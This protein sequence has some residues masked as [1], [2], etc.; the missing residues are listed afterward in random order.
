MQK[1]ELSNSGKSYVVATTKGCVQTDVK[2]EGKPL[3]LGLNAFIS[4]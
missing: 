3:T 4:K 2:V 1:P